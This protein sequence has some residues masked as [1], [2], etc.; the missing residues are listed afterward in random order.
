V[1]FFVKKRIK[2]RFVS[3]TKNQNIGYFL[4]IRIKI[5]IFLGLTLDFWPF[6]NKNAEWWDKKPRYLLRKPPSRS[7]LS[8]AFAYGYSSIKNVFYK[9][10]KEMPELGISRKRPKRFI[11]VT[12]SVVIITRWCI[13]KDP[14]K[15]PY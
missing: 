2:K 14:D 1:Y 13:T 4:T 10:K 12:I 8:S 7:F 6:S 15:K 11:L 3:K 9:R 5:L